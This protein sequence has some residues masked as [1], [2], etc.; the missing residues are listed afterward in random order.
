MSVRY[1]SGYIGLLL[2]RFLRKLARRTPARLPE[3]LALLPEYLAMV[4][5][6]SAEK[7]RYARALWS[8]HKSVEAQSRRARVTSGLSDIEQ[9]LVT[10]CHLAS[11]STLVLAC[12]AGREALALAKLGVRVEAVDWSP[13]L[14]ARARREAERAGLPISFEVVDLYDLPDREPRFDT[15]W[16][17]NRGYSLLTPEKR[18]V[19]FLQRARSL[20]KPGGSLLLSFV[21]GAA[22]ADPHRLTA[23]LDRLASK[24]VH[25]PLF[26]PEYERGDFIADGGLMVHCFLDPAALKREFHRAGFLVQ[27]WLWEEGFAVLA[28]EDQGLGDSPKRGASYR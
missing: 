20:L 19:R 12:G 22:A 25:Q 5:W 27:E 24:L 21:S 17:T 3:R 4:V 14:V 16:L 8:S 11:G 7:D 10:R 9:E 23:S 18:R 13:G 15:L 26:S 6:T 2:S 28:S 1:L